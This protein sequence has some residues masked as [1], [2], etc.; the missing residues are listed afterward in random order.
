MNRKIVSFL[1]CLSLL[2]VCLLSLAGCGSAVGEG[3]DTRQTVDIAPEPGEASDALDFAIR[4]YRAAYDG[5]N[6]LLSPLSVLAA[7]AMTANGAKGETK[8]QM[9]S[10]LGM[11]VE[12]LNA[13]FAEYLANLPN[14]ENCKLA[15]ADAIWIR[16][17]DRLTVKDG[18][19]NTNADVYRAVAYRTSFDAAAVDEINRWVKEKT[20]E[21]I[22][23]FVDE[24]PRE[25]MVLILNALAFDAKWAEPYRQ[26]SEVRPDDFTKE[27]GEKVEVDYLCGRESLYLSDGDRAVGFVKPYA[28]GRYAFA[29]L[30]PAEGT[31]VADYIASL[32]GERLATILKNKQ[33]VPVEI[34]LPKFEVRSELTLNEDLKTLGITAAFDGDRADFSGIADP[35]PFTLYI[36]RVLHKTYIEVGEIGTRAAAVTGVFLDAYSGAYQEN[37]KIVSLDR[38]FVYLIWDVENG[39][40][41]FIGT[42]NDPS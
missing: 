26:E 10:A 27:N 22:E 6:T 15:L 7:L 11:T 19:L 2:F 21:M 4:L 29:A 39:L 1:L 14:G 40:P 42:L 34:R 32:D 25:T 8:S 12:E 9:E 5:N 35:D 30:L 3:E 41:L 38:P 16:N 20:D 24:I 13:F 18:F 37:P 23:K 28:G 31:A 36:S 17:E 33:S